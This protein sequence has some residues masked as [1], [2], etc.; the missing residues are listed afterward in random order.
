MST[1]CADNLMFPTRASDG[2]NAGRRLLL[3]HWGDVIGLAARLLDAGS[4]ARAEIADPETV[5]LE[6]GF[7]RTQRVAN[8]LWREF[9]PCGVDVDDLLNVPCV[10]H[11]NDRARAAVARHPI[12]S[13][14]IVGPKTPGLEHGFSQSRQMFPARNIENSVVIDIG[15]RIPASRKSKT[16]ERKWG[17]GGS[18]LLGTGARARSLGR[19]LINAVG[20]LSAFGEIADIV[21]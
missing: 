13:P 17:F 15:V 5:S 14:Q 7:N 6:R 1:S 19:V 21:I 12:Q 3:N 20:A 10:E 4:L 2:L 16:I 9:A 8:S 18:S 11:S